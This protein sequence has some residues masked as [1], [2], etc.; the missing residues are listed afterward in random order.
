MFCHTSTQSCYCTETHSKVDCPTS[1]LSRFFSSVS[2]QPF[3]P[4]YRTPISSILI[5]PLCSSMPCGFA[6]TLISSL[7]E[8]WLYL[9]SWSHLFYGIFSSKQ[10]QCM[11][12]LLEHV[13]HLKFLSMVMSP[14]DREYVPYHSFTVAGGFIPCIQNTLLIKFYWIAHR[15]KK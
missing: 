2:G 11:C 12:P 3:H 7:S 13:T 14:G 6:Q 5:R 1:G 8:G 9:S 4:A 10:F 15:R